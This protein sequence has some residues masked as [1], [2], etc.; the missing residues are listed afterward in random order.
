MKEKKQRT[1]SF[2][3]QI[4]AFGER[5]SVFVPKNLGFKSFPVPICI[6][7]FLQTLKNIL[8]SESTNKDAT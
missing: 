3:V 8:K 6:K 2:F 7:S 4:V 1:G 5:E